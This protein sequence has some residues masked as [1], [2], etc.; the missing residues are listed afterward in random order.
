V[1][2]GDLQAEIF[3]ELFLSREK[4]CCFPWPGDS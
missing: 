1:E 2:A 4:G 3:S